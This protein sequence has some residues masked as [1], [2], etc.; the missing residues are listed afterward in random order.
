MRV[1]GV[2]SRADLWAWGRV[3]GRW[4]CKQG[5]GGGGG[6]GGNAIPAPNVDRIFQTVTTSRQIQF[7]LKMTFEI[8]DALGMPPSSI[9]WIAQRFIAI[10]YIR[11]VEDAAIV[12]LVDATS[13]L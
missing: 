13:G 10:N 11:Y 12:E 6:L 7:W 4:G 5:A 3:G 8:C 1:R 9:F 2:G